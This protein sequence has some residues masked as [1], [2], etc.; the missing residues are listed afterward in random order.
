M[1][2]YASRL[3]ASQHFYGAYYYRIKIVTFDANYLNRDVFQQI[4]CHKISKSV[5][6]MT[7]LYDFIGGL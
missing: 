3:E 1:V 2:G 5:L 6:A 4:L 7:L